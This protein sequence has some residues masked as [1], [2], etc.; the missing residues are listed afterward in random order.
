ME[1]SEKSEI[2]EYNDSL[3]EYSPE[4]I[5]KRERLHE[6]FITLYKKWEKDN[7]SVTNEEFYALFDVRDAEMIANTYTGRFKYYDDD[8]PRYDFAEQVV[9]P[10][11][12]K[13]GI[14]AKKKGAKDYEFVDNKAGRMQALDF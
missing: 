9:L 2:E 5:E 13:K 6:E 7:T 11:C 10:Y 1:K 14:L 4:E 12:I 8:R 3:P